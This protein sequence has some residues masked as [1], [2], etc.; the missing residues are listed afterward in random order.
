MIPCRHLYGYFCQAP[1]DEPFGPPPEE[2]LY[3]CPVCREEMLVNE[4]IIDVAVGA[5]KFRG[6]YEGD[7]LKIGCPG[8]NRETMEYVDQES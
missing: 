6:E 3:R 5:A 1:L 7:M 4:A 8:C 2:Y